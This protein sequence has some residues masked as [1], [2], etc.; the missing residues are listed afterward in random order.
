MREVAASTLALAIRVVCIN[1]NA[2]GWMLMIVEENRHKDQESREVGDSRWQHGLISGGRRD[3]VFL[4]DRTTVPTDNQEGYADLF[5]TVGANAERY[6]QEATDYESQG[7]L[8]IPAS[9][10]SWRLLHAN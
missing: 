6:R 10:P 2:N 5:S 1:S 9:P 4:C 3:H 8:K 7:I